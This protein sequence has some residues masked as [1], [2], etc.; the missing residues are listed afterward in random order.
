MTLRPTFSLLVGLLGLILGI[1][2]AWFVKPDSVPT[3]QQCDSPKFVTEH[4]EVVSRLDDVLRRLAV[5]EESIKNLSEVR[6][7]QGPEQQDAARQ[8]DVDLR[9][10]FET[11]LNRIEGQIQEASLGLGD[12]V[13]H[14]GQLN[15]DNLS[16]WQ[17]EFDRD[18][19]KVT[20]RLKG[21]T[22]GDAALEFGDPSLQIEHDGSVRTP[23]GGHVTS[24]IWKLPNGSF[25]LIIGFE[26]G[27]GVYS[28]CGEASVLR[29]YLT[30]LRQK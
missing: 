11:R 28:G 2:V 13:R 20:T 14:S 12:A 19:A 7:G 18:G 27:I 15:L 21:M 24:W 16:K 29:D 30:L 1:G 3:G 25:T 4:R 23:Q 26:A 8:D 9:S 22:Q 17:R 10:Y 5:L 6:R